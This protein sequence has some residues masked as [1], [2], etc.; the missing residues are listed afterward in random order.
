MIMICNESIPAEDC[1]KIHTSHSLCHVVK[2]QMPAYL[3]TPINLPHTHIELW[4]SRDK[5]DLQLFT[6]DTY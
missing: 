5:S 4:A 1:Y 6:L 2:Q 3:E